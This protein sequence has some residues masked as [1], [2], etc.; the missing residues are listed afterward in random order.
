MIGLSSRL[1]ISRIRTNRSGLDVL[2]ILAFAVTSFL[3]LT[4]AGGTSMF[5][6]RYNNPPQAL[7]D[8][9]SNSEYGY[10]SAQEFAQNY[11]FLA[12]VACAILVVP[13]L[14]LGGGA[15]RLGA[16]GRARRLA[17]LRLIGMTGGEVVLMSVIE[18]VVLTVAGALFGSLLFALSLPL[19]QFVSFHSSP[20][21]A[22]EMIA[23]WWVNGALVVVI[24]VLSAL[25]TVI[26]LQRVVISPLGVARRESPKALKFWRVIAFAFASVLFIVASQT[27]NLRESD[28]MVFATIAGVLVLL[29]FTVNLVGPWLIQLIARPLARSSSP[30]TVLAMRRLVAQPRDAWRNVAALAFIGFI[31]AFMAGMPVTPDDPIFNLQVKDISTGTMVTLVI[32]MVVAATS[33]LINQAAFTVDRADQTVALTRMGTPRQVFGAARYRQVLLPLVATL[34]LAIPLGFLAMATMTAATPGF[35]IEMS[36]LTGLLGVVLFGFVLCLAAASASRPIESRILTADYRR[37][38]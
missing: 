32:G 10:W 35:R 23:P 27:F 17:S 12:I 19:W 33:T 1:A 13:I 4:V 11:V 22:G 2:A 20:I 9:V 18:S 14:G 6:D 28:F 26:G 30:A 15:A 7:V 21:S 3:A 31:A 38:D 25:S 36:G 24:L 29:L 8:V 37:N 16:S 34:G 5:I